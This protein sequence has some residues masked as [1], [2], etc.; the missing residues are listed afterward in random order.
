MGAMVAL[1]RGI[2]VGG[3][4]KLAMADLRAMAEACG[5]ADVA[6]YIQS[7][8]LVFSTTTPAA[9]AGRALAEA[10]AADSD[11]TTSVVIRTRTQ[12]ADVVAE[13]PFLARGEDPGS[14][15]VTFL[16]PDDAPSLPDDPKTFAPDEAIVVG[17]EVH[18]FLPEG[19][20]RSKL[21]ARATRTGTTRN[22]RTVTK[23]L[24]M[25]QSID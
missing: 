23:L 7:G 17:S 25:V 22:W 21:A 4:G 6:T 3:K 18:L 15:H 19:L 9:A 14:L 2:N 20:G 13:S 24:E 1:L 16:G 10:I 5:F 12:L 8:N 11:V